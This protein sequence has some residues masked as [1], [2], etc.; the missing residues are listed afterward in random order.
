MFS[1]LPLPTYRNA[2]CNLD[3]VV[4]LVIYDLSC[5]TRAPRPVVTAAKWPGEAVWGCKLS[6]MI[7]VSDLFRFLS[8]QNYCEIL[9]K[10]G[11]NPL[12]SFDHSVVTSMGI[13]I[14]LAN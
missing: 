11:S 7:S 10:Y 1:K 3:F 2:G 14:I 9:R 12:F 8:L 5:K 4:G 6:P 13:S